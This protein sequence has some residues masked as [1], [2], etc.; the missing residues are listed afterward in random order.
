M[1]NNSKYSN[2]YDYNKEIGVYYKFNEGITGDVAIDQVVLD[3]GG[4]ISNGVWTGYTSGIGSRNTGSAILSASAASKE[5]RDPIIY[6]SHPD[7]ASLK[8]S[9]LD[10]GS[11]HD[12]NN[13][14]FKFS[15]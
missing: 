6:T 11:Y 7:V 14:T 5:Y 8:K 15:A 10:S 2:N 1:I 12:L 9:L 4:R 3:Y 13:Q